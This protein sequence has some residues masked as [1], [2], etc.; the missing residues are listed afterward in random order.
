[1]DESR[2]GQ[3]SIYSAAYG[4]SP[5]HAGLVVVSIT[6]VDF[7]LNLKTEQLKLTSPVCSIKNIGQW[8]MVFNIILCGGPQH[9]GGGSCKHTCKHTAWHAVTTWGD[10][11]C[12]VF[13]EGERERESERARGERE[14]ARARLCV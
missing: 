11:R 8:N 10:Q 14:R 2:E 4:D 12:S 9:D 13:R 3:V 5:N 1:M 7:I 6:S